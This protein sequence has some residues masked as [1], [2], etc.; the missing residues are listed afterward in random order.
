[1]VTVSVVVPVLNDAS[2]LRRLIADLRAAPA[3]EI[4]VVDGGSDD[5]SVVAAQAADVVAATTR[6]RGGQMRLGAARASGDWLWFVH[7][8]TRVSSAALAA[9]RNFGATPGW[10]WFVVRLDSSRTA[11][12]I[13][14]TTMNWR[15]A[16][17]GIATGDHG[18]FVHRRLLDAI[19][20]VPEQALLEDV[21]MCKRLRRLAKPQRCQ[22]PID[23]S[24]RRWE[25]HGV[26]R[27]VVTMWQL[28]LRY[29]FGANPDQLARS[30][31]G[32]GAD[33]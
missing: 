13:V 31:Y 10:G 29:C 2:A 3:L 17:T 21:E 25:Q 27:T 5:D 24:A 20:G 11:L 7:A 1:M 28:R 15:T 4:V 30:Y 32:L 8:D 26:V 9:V 16:A 23:T 19:G 14:E 6:G 18:I 33:S 12:R 22:A